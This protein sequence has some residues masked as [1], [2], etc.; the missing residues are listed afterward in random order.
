MTDTAMIFAAGLG[1]RL[2]P[3]TDDRP[4]ALVEL[5]GKTML[6]RT[7]EKLI[8]SGVRRIIVN[9]HHFPE[10]MCVAIDALDYEGV[11][12]IISDESGELLDTGGGLLKAAEHLKGKQPFIVHNVDVISDIDLVAMYENHLREGALASLAVSRRDTSRYFN[13]HRGRLCGW[14]NIRTKEEMNCYPVDGKPDSLAFSGIHIINPE[15]FDLITERGKFS[16][17]QVYLRLAHEQSI[18][19]YEHD[20][21]YWADIGT[22]E[23]LA[24]AEKMLLSHPEKF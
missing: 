3:L 10:K 2:A 6:Q 8:R 13:W 14:K 12:F 4:K 15:I 17:N 20:A 22:T 18:M 7:V 19:A 11:E 23:K 5:G 1:T 16:I 24:A 9:I 21:C